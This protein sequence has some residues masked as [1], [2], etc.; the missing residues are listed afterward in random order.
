MYVIT[1]ATGNIGSKT[2]NILLEQGEP[3]RVIGRDAGR[4]EPFRARGAEVAVGDLKDSDFLTE[5]FAGATAV[6]VMIPPHLHTDDFRSFQN[7]VGAAIAN[8]IRKAKVRFVVNLSSQ[9]ADLAQGTGPI[10]GLRDQEQRLNALEGINILHLRP[11][12][13]MENLLM[14]IPV[15]NRFG[16]AGSAVR[17]DQQFAMIATADIAAHLA[18]RLL[19]RNFEGI[20]VQDLLGE[21]DLSLN[22]AFAV[23][24]NK[25]GKP[26]LKYVQ[27]PYQDAERGM[28]EMGL[29]RDLSRR[30]IEM[31]K[32]LNDGMFAVR[33]PRVPGT[34]TPTSIE[35]FAE[36]FAKA[37]AA[38]TM[39]E[40]I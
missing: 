15:I 26:D 25:I 24:G 5:A 8:A 31:S 18:Q 36:T 20:R 1:G 2:A 22:E 4:L 40:G 17:G 39:G 3:V 37:F 9:G 21:R 7:F 34:T 38:S 29:S 11:T 16:F 35:M 19:Q 13:F 33:R 23:L 27:F 14:Q 32:A 10:I 28:V 6:Y 12:Y 30:Y